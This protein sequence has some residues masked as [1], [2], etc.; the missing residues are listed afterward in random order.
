APAIYPGPPEYP[1]DI[2]EEN[3]LTP[4]PSTNTEATQAEPIYKIQHPAYEQESIKI[5][6]TSMTPITLNSSGTEQPQIPIPEEA[7]AEDITLS[8]NGGSEESAKIILGQEQ[9]VDQE[10]SPPI[11]TAKNCKSSR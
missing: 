4:V 3:Y 9:G 1:E 2:D 6:D 11:C 8:H 7:Q 10:K 5:S